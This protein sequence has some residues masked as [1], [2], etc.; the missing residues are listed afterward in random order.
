MANKKFLL[1]RAKNAYS[2][3]GVS[4]I[5]RKA[6][7]LIVYSITGKFTSFIV[8]NRQLEFGLNC[9]KRKD[10]IVVSLTSFPQRFPHLDMCL[11]SL[12]IQKV[13]PDKIIVYLGNDSSL[14][15]MTA[16]MRKFQDYGVE[17]RF[18]KTMNL[19]PHKKYYY[20]MQEYPHSIIVTADDDII[21]P[22]NWLK[23]LYESYK[24]YPN[25]VSARRVHQIK[26]D[27][28]GKMISYD[29]WKDQCRSLKKPSKQ[30]VAT[31]NGGILYPPKCLPKTAF[32]VDVIKQL[33]L[34]TDDLWLKCMEV[35]NNV[36]VVWVK[37]WQVKPVS[38]DYEDNSRLQDENIFTGKN[39]LVMRAI[40]KYCSI[41]DKNFE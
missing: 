15:M 35:K 32:N 13:K 31:G 25:A 38:I 10:H 21:Y 8:R 5:V 29:K 26:F 9:S 39:D 18:D 4:E 34:R 27:E 20:A 14:D 17:Y 40:M 41:T 37:N 30:L 36:P 11:K 1:E 6:M 7:F 23:T 22:R 12:V 2:Y 24:L 16:T 33:C 19:M 28:Q 3:G